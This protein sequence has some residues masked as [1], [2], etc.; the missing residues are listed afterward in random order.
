[1]QGNDE[2]SCGG[3]PSSTLSALREMV[4]AYT[5][6]P[7]KVTVN[8]IRWRLDARTNS[9]VIIKND[10]FPNLKIV[11]F[12]EANKATAIIRYSLDGK[13]CVDSVVFGGSYS[14]N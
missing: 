13:G 5:L 4:I 3:V 11:F 8:G 9:S 1:M 6:G 14:A 10:E 12:R 2:P 7:M